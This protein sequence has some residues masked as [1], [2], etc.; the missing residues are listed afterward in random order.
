MKIRSKIKK[1][2][3]DELLKMCAVTCDTLRIN[4]SQHKM[5]IIQQ[6]LKRYGV[7]FSVLGGA[8][9]RLT[10]YIDG[11]A[12][13]F[14]IDGQGYTDNLIEYSISRELQPYVTK[15]Y[16]TNGYILVAE[17]VKTMSLDDFKLRR[18]DIESI[19]STLA[20]DYLLGDVGIT[21]KNYTNWGIRDDGS[22]VILDYA[23]IHRG[24]EKLFTCEVCGS[25]I[26]RYDPTYT[27]L[28]C[29]NATSCGAEFT[30][31]QR[32][33]V[34]GDKI[35]LD[36]IDDAKHESIILGKGVV[37]KDVSVDNGK[38]VS[39]NKVIINNLP[40]YLKYLKEVNNKMSTNFNA[41]LAL[42]LMA[43]QAMAN[44]DAEREAIEKE[45]SAVYSET[46]D[47]DTEVVYE[48]S[49]DNMNYHDEDD[50]DDNQ[51]E[52]V[53]DMADGDYGYSMA[54]MVRIANGKVDVSEVDHNYCCDCGD[55]HKTQS[56]DTM[57]Y[58]MT[59]GDY[60]LSM[61]DLV[62]KAMHSTDVKDDEVPAN[63]TGN[64]PEVTV[65]PEEE[66]ASEPVKSDGEPTVLDDGVYFNGEKL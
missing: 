22:V 15:T 50:E 6:L 9:N 37:E 49:Y 17:C 65:V 2:F 36:M 62:S 24:T 39:G 60:A 61:A 31:I 47:D 46:E 43:K 28:K 19:L 66:R 7:N 42:K 55:S 52:P 13:K 29:S 63:T 59:D 1:L 4:S 27:K 38:I 25:G 5:L 54:D 44:T 20:M 32:K 21:E 16:E 11:Y 45:L 57:G 8:T 18:S 64:D 12:I 14:A 40:D 23:Y 26:L 56:D 48:P 51:E 41:E 3:P 30:Y 35:D 10:L 34:Q 58:Y 33:A 53:P